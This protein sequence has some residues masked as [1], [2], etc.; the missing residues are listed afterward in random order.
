MH[1]Y[2]DILHKSSI[3]ARFHYV[4]LVPVEV[5]EESFSHQHQTITWNVMHFSD[6]IR[7]HKTGSNVPAAH[8]RQSNMVLLLL[9]LQPVR[10]QV[11]MKGARCSKPLGGIRRQKERLKKV[12]NRGYEI[13]SLCF[14][15]DTKVGVN[16]DWPSSKRTWEN[17]LTVVYVRD[18]P[19]ID[20][21]ANKMFPVG[22]ENIPWRTWVEQF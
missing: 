19:S 1:S 4:D 16:A 18:F 9:Q 22:S 10:A 13:K 6:K 2:P 11:S 8:L 21:G 20:T 5:Q 3:R 12:I 7:L 17:R 15:V 14:F